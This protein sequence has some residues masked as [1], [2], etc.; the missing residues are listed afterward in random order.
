MPG[1]PVKDTSPSSVS[2]DRLHAAMR[3]VNQILLG[4]ER[5]VE[6]AFSCLLSQGHLLIEDLPGVNFLSKP[7]NSMA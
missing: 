2:L 1:I 7:C 6:L 3:T 4:K 5:Q